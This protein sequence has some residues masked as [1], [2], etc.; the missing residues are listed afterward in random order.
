MWHQF[1]WCTKVPVGHSS[2][3]LWSQC[4]GGHD[5]S[6]AAAPPVSPAASCA[7]H[8]CAS[9]QSQA[10][11]PGGPRR[12]R[13]SLHH[14]PRD[15]RYLDQCE[16]Q[17][18]TCSHDNPYRFHFS[19]TVFSIQ[20]FC[21]CFIILVA[22]LLK[23]ESVTCY[24]SHFAIKLQLKRW[25]KYLYHSYFSFML[26]VHDIFHPFLQTSD[27]EFTFITVNESKTGFCHLYK[28]TSVLQQRSYNWAK[29]YTHSE[30]NTVT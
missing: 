30:G 18:Y 6:T 21:V 10:G 20:Q 5:G 3:S 16:F 1:T 12:R 26:Q 14:L 4:V 8:S 25:M 24:L 11:E 15:Q 29:G 23:N 7:F 17:H 9:G 13:P 28:I 27:D 22:F 19:L 2:S